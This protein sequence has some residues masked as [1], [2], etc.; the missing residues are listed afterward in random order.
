MLRELH[1]D[2]GDRQV[3]GSAGGGA[4]RCVVNGH[5]EIE[6]IRI[7]PAAVDPAQV[8]LLEDLVTAAVR[9][10]VR[11]A[12]DLKKAETEKVTGGILPDLGF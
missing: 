12:L 5:L 2:L 11:A 9:Q 7:D 3:E 8:P 6:S 1:R 10:A 4:V